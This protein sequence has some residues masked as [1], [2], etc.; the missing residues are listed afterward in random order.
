MSIDTATFVAG[1]GVLVGL[2]VLSLTI[3]YG[4]ARDVGE[5]QHAR[6][7]AAKAKSAARDAEEQAQCVHERL[8]KHLR[9]VHN[10]VTETATERLGRE[11]RGRP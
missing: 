2:D 5:D 10:E 8:T 9:R 3:L 1:V 4:L 6:E 7:Q 11:E